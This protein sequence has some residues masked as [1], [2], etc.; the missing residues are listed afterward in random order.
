MLVLACIL[1]FLLIVFLKKPLIWASV[2]GALCFCAGNISKINLIDFDVLAIKSG[3][4]CLE[5]GNIILGSVFF[6]E[7]LKLK[8]NLASIRSSIEALKLNSYQICVLLCMFLCSFIEGTAG[9]GL[10]ALVVAPIL[11]NQGFGALA[12]ICLPLSMTCLSVVFGAVCSPIKIGL[13]GFDVQQVSHWSRFLIILPAL[14]MPV[15]LAKIN[16]IKSENKTSIMLFSSLVY[17]VGIFIGYLLGIEFPV[18]IAGSLGLLACPFILKNNSL[19]LN[20]WKVFFKSLSPFFLFVIV[21]LMLKLSFSTL[22][23]T[24][25][26]QNETIK[27]VNLVQSGLV[28]FVL[29]LAI[30]FRNV[31]YLSIAGKIAFTKLQKV[32]PSIFCLVF[33]AFLLKNEMATAISEL[34]SQIPDYF[35][36]FASCLAGVMGASITGSATM[37]NIL[38][39]TAI[40]TN[41]SVFLA[42]NAFNL[43]LLNI[44]GAL[45]NAVS[46]Q[47]MLVASTSLSEKIQTKDILKINLKV[48]SVYILAVFISTLFLLY[49]LGL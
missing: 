44:G 42:N 12:S 38:L 31:H 3:V 28:F 21:F 35:I 18:I 40:Q 34:F 20:H 13:A 8:G 49:Y 1:I 23:Y 26:Y 46:F 5:I 27:K 41:S 22:F 32:L 15:I 36:P 29:G 17:I 6:L 30:S 11:F 45:G 4:V 10:P 24:I 48:V 37:S 43:A 39:G 9:F 16:P 33:F 47:N 7:I 14:L 19:Q 25:T 2:A